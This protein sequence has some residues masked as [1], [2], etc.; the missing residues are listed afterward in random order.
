MNDIRSSRTNEAKF[1]R[2]TFPLCVDVAE[3]LQIFYQRW[4]KQIFKRSKI[5]WLN[6]IVIRS[7]GCLLSRFHFQFRSV[8]RSMETTTNLNFKSR[9]QHLITYQDV[10]AKNYLLSQRSC[11][12]GRQS[13]PE[14]FQRLTFFR[15]IWNFTDFSIFTMIFVGNMSNFGRTPIKWIE[16]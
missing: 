1:F 16:L 6:I 14:N 11:D 2:E 3:F 10:L 7:I 12:L 4:R 8:D 15:E 13:S 5:V 9:L